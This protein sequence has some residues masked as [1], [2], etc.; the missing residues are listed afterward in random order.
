[1][2]SVGRGVA[3]R[4]TGEVASIS[5]GLR[6]MGRVMGGTPTCSGEAKG[7]RISGDW[8]RGGGPSG[9]G[10][11]LLGLEATGDPGELLVVARRPSGFSKSVRKVRCLQSDLLLV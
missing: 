6:M 7:C 1:M 9:V 4:G 5:A 8:V 2:G 11:R 3:R 10:L